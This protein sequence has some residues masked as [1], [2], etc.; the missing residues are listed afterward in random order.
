MGS[1]AYLTQV[2]QVDNHSDSCVRLPNPAPL[3][4]LA[5][6]RIGLLKIPFKRSPSAELA[7]PKWCRPASFCFSTLES[8]SFSLPY[9]DL[10]LDLGLV[11]VK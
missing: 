5:D 10:D 3:I 7:A 1:D 6:T 8:E 9:S 4:D 11:D 2:Q